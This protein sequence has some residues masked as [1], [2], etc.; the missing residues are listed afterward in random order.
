MLDTERIARD[1][2][3]GL[4]QTVALQQL[5]AELVVLLYQIGRDCRS[6]ADDGFEIVAE[7]ILSELLRERERHLRKR[8]HH[9]EH[10]RLEAP[11][12]AE[13]V[14]VVIA[15]EQCA[16]RIKRGHQVADQTEH[17]RERENQ[18]IALIKDVPNAVAAVDGSLQHRAVREKRALALSRG[19]ARE[20]HHAGCFRVTI[21]HFRAVKG[22]CRDIDNRQVVELLPYNVELRIQLGLIN[23][24]V[25]LE[26]HAAAKYAARVEMRRQNDRRH[27]EGGH[28]DERLDKIVGI[29]AE[30]AHSAAVNLLQQ[31]RAEGSRVALQFFIGVGCVAEHNRLSFG[32]VAQTVAPHPGDGLLLDNTLKFLGVGKGSEILSRV[33]GMPPFALSDNVYFLIV[34]RNRASSSSRS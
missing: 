16:A 6:A 3:G 14:L 31:H 10:G 9:D 19:A 15:N 5:D 21:A 30:N 18:Q 1:E 33:H 32:V 23:Q 4:G 12:I 34:S 28:G 29:G 22:L 24:R 25:Q 2:V 20:H 17:M 11:D 7:H 8:G 26:P 27:A 13:H